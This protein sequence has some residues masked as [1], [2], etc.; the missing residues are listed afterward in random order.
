MFFH[1]D[2]LQSVIVATKKERDCCRHLF[3]RKVDDINNRDEC[4][5]SIKKERNNIVQNKLKFLTPYFNVE[6]RSQTNFNREKKKEKFFGN[7]SRRRRK[8]KEEEKK[9][10][11][12]RHTSNNDIRG[13]RL[14]SFSQLLFIH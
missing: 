13:S 1:F 5:K 8:K 7:E 10:K 14:H 2:Q 6:P 9:K 12:S 11:Y 4:Q 3:N